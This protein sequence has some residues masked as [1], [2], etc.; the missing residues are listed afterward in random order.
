MTAAVVVSTGARA[1]AARTAALASRIPG[2]QRSVVQLEP[3]G[4]GFT[5]ETR[6][7]RSCAGVNAGAAASISDAVPATIGAAK[8]VPPTMPK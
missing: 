8:L 5:V 6:I 4:K 2:P 3:A 7:E 1:F